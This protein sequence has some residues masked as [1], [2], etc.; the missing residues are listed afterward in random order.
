VSAKRILISSV[1]AF[2]LA[3]GVAS[4][5]SRA[6]YRVALADGSSFAAADR[7]VQ[8]G[9]VVVFHRFPEMSLVGVPEE[10][11]VA[12]EALDGSHAARVLA[13]DADR[14]TV[15]STG[16][17]P[18]I[19]EPGEVVDVG[20]TGGTPAAA[21]VSAP[22]PAASGGGFDSRLVGYG[23]G[24]FPGTN[25]ADA[26][27]AAAAAAAA[28]QAAPQAPIAA[29]G[30]PSAPLTATAIGA[31]GTPVFPGV[32]GSASAV[33]G[34]DGTP[35]M[36]NPGT[37]GA[38]TPVIGANGTPVI[39]P[40]GTPGS[41]QPAIGANGTP[42][43][44]PGGAPGSAAPTIGPNGTPVPAT[45]FGPTPGSAPVG[46]NGF[47]APAPPSSGGSPRR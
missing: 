34:P 9:S 19:L 16:D 24:F 20:I 8:R 35:I 38:T 1:L 21:V 14:A 12:V 37:P 32:P 26:A 11:V 44:A 22:A 3:A 25:P 2:G 31:N 40:A 36:A 7:P 42:V 43:L 15:V 39:A 47:P 45:G 29:N 27:A 41:A 17:N 4:A 13:A 6:R 10:D 30:F 46:P 28:V 5:A 33:I 18:R 23:G